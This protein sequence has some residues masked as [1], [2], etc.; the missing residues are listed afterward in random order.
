MSEHC[1]PCARGRRG[2]LDHGVDAAGGLLGLG[3][4]GL[5]DVV[6]VADDPARAGR[7]QPDQPADVTDARH[8]AHA[9]GRGGRRG[10]ELGG[11][12]YLAGVRGASVTGDGGRQRGRGQ[13]E[14]RAGDQ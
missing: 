2:R 11:E 10:R 7:A 14:Q 5:A 1:R 3:Q 4:R 12:C 6:Q 9:A 8:L 13:A